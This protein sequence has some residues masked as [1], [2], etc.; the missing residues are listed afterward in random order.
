MAF[1]EIFPQ[2]NMQAKSRAKKLTLKRQ[3]PPTLK[4]RKRYFSL[5]VFKGNDNLHVFNIP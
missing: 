4:K 3:F 1:L 2:K 5:I